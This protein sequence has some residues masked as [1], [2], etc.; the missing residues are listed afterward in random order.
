MKSASRPRPSTLPVWVLAGVGGVWLDRGG[1]RPRKG[2]S[3]ASRSHNRH[4]EGIEPI[5]IPIPCLQCCPVM[6]LII[7]GGKKEDLRSLPFHL[8]I[9]R[10]GK[11]CNSERESSVGAVSTKGDRTHSLRG[12]GNSISH[13]GLDCSIC[14]AFL[15]SEAASPSVYP[16]LGLPLPRCRKGNRELDRLTNGT[17][18]RLRT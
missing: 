7:G 6:I 13:L 18:Q 3:T 1:A 15:I 9:T 12:V 11:E 5:N 14:L 16:S 4:P 2:S 10:R 17:D 8:S